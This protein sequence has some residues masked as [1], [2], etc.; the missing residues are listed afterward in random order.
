MLLV[1]VKSVEEIESC[2]DYFGLITFVI[3]AYPL[4]AS[5]DKYRVMLIHV[6]SYLK[7][8]ILEIRRDNIILRDVLMY[9]IK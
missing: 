6:I 9:N 7:S 1:P 2:N 4:N 5:L 3:L 8:L